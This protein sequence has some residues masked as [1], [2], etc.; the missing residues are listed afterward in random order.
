MS[1]SYSLISDLYGV[2]P[3]RRQRER[4]GNSG[5]VIVLALAG[6]FFY[7]SVHPVLRL[8]SNPPADFVQ[9]AAN[10]KAS[11]RAQQESVARSYWSLAADFVSG[12]Y[13]YGDAL[14]VNPPADFT[15]A[16]GEDYATRALYWQRLRDLWSEQSA[17][18]TS[19]EFN[20]DWISTS[21]ESL[22]EYAKDH[23]DL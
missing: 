11:V 16:S 1:N 10:R 6:V 18:A 5:L 7:E 22:R 9:A 19:Y 13:S 2:E 17:W 23:F 3:A 12:K 21:L 4:R 15:L 20:A 8:R 14:P